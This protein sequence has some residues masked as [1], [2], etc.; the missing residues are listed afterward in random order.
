MRDLRICFIGDSYINGSGDEDCLGWIGRLCRRRFDRSF[1]LTFYDLGIRG[2]TTDEIRDR[3]KREATARFP[4]G[5]DNRVVLQFG[6]NDVAEITGSG[7]RVEEDVSI[8]N[9]EAIVREVSGLYPTLWVGVPPANVA[10]SPMR[11]SAGM[12]IVFTQESAVALNQ[13]YLE[14]AAQLKVPYLDIQTPLLANDRYMDSLTRGDRMHCD[15]SGYAIM[16]EIVDRWEPWS[17]WFS[18]RS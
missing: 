1:R 7:R 6:I 5:A 13:R 11:P 10:C 2:A 12:E 9:A 3:W 15:G 17:D 16:A 14:T 18:D 4:E 8:A